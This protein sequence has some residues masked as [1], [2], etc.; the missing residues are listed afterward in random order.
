ME[1]FEFKLPPAENSS[2]TQISGTFPTY[3]KA[4]KI[5]GE[6]VGDG[7]TLDFGAGLGL[8]QLKLN[9][10]TFEPYPRG[11]FVPTYTDISKIKDS[12]YKRLTSLNVLNVVS[13]DVRNTIVKSIGQILSVGGVAIIT[14][15]GKDVLN[16]KGII[17][18]EPMS[19]VTTIDTYQKG[20]TK[21]ELLEYVSSTLGENYRVQPLKLGP[22][23]CT[24][25]KLRGEIS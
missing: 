13:L 25:T 6:L 19:I 16:C 14:T 4:D 8:S 2:K 12:S 7:K 22:A 20:F 10:D 9:Y 3:L 5:L 23:G 15:R 18:Q 11:K 17:G 24:I 1:K 21:K